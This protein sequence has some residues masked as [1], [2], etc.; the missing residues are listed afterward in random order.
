[1]PFW[2]ISY[3]AAY[4][5]LFG[6]WIFMRSWPRTLLFVAALAL[7]GLKPLALA[8]A[9]LL[10]VW[11]RRREDLIVG[12]RAALALALLP[13]A[14]YAAA[15]D[16]G[17]PPLLMAVTQVSIGPEA[18]AALRFSDE[19][20]WNA[21]LGALVVVHLIGVRS[22]GAV[23]P[24]RKPG[25]GRPATWL[26]GATFSIY[27]VHY[28]ALQLLDALIP[29]DAAPILRDAGL[30]LGAL[31]VSLIFAQAF[32]RTLPRLRRSLEG[33]GAAEPL[34]R[35]PAQPKDRAKV[36]RSLTD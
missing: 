19:F 23:R 18:T 12:D 21:L 6:I 34:K 3:E 32:E 26:A 15:V 25:W 33:W 29:Q 36:E 8:P 10:G 28:P 4:Y 9:W 35:R 5:A 14:I 1:G 16:I 7:F 17:L 13:L 24:D 30:L 20:L 31:G 22:L 2:S 27:L 11:L